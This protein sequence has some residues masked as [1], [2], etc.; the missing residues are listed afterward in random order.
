M[1]VCVCVCV[2]V[3]LCIV[4]VSVCMCLK[5]SRKGI[6]EYKGAWGIFTMVTEVQFVCA[7]ACARVWVC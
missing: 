4:C 6:D 1:C 7:C 5:S 3:C 2:F